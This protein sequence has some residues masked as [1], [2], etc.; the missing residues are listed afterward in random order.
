MKILDR[1]IPEAGF[2]S[3]KWSRDG[4]D[5]VTI[6][7]MF[8][9]PELPWSKFCATRTEQCLPEIFAFTSSRRHDRHGFTT[10]VF[11]MWLNGS[12]SG[13]KR[14]LASTEPETW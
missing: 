12:E 7:T 8:T 3:K 2:E 5:G 11:P 6:V 9:I 10:A 14:V 13:P 1:S 4:R